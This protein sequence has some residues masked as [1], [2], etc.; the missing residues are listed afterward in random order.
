[1]KPRKRSRASR[2]AIATGGAPS[3]ARKVLR[4]AQASDNLPGQFLLIVVAK[5]GARSRVRLRQVLQLSSGFRL[6]F[7]AELT[8]MFAL[9]AAD[10][11]VRRAIS[12]PRFAEPA[13][14]SCTFRSPQPYAT[15]VGTTGSKRRPT[16]TIFIHGQRPA[17]DIHVGR[18]VSSLRFAVNFLTSLHKSLSPT[19]NAASGN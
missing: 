16:G 8:S 7:P 4:L 9:P 18:V 14:S 5:V 2:A 3:F 12:S 15:T 19:A 6:A 17:D 1:L 10:L 11:H 13:G